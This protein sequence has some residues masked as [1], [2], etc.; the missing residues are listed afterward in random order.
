LDDGHGV[1][2]SLPDEELETMLTGCDA[3]LVLVGH[4]HWPLDRQCGDVRVV[5]PG[6]VSY[7]WGPDVRGSY[8]VIDADRAGYQV[9]IHRVAFD[10][11]AVIESI[12]ASG[13]YPNPEWLVGRLTNAPRAPWLPPA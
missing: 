3:D 13:F 1:S 2:P 5:N 4:T 9:E 6:S 7:P 10:I 8:A 11:G 12:R